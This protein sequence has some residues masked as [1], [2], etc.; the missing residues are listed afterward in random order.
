MSSNTIGIFVR[1]TKKGNESVDRI[2]DTSQVCKNLRA[3][4]H[5]IC[6]SDIVRFGLLYVIQNLKLFEANPDLLI[7]SSRA[8]STEN[9][10]LM[11]E[12]R[13]EK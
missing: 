3:K 4:G 6:K 2:I 7:A 5:S 1:M 9:L 12:R 10:L 13:I 11:T 8:E